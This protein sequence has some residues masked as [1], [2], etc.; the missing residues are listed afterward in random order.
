MNI[1]QELILLGKILKDLDVDR[2][3][4]IIKYILPLLS[5]LNEDI[6]PN[7]FKF[8]NINR[9]FEGCLGDI[10]NLLLPEHIACIIEMNRLNINTID[11][12]LDADW[13]YFNSLG[14][15]QN[16]DKLEILLRCDGYHHEDCLNS[17]ITSLEGCDKQFCHECVEV[18][19]EEMEEDC[20]SVRC[21]GCSD[22]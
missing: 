21:G 13:S 12:Y 4:I 7:F 15:C 22:L 11:E 20:Y 16:C 14:K 18:N 8:E 9:Y 2:N 17:E 5:D 3:I 1:E 10:M 6:P 19:C